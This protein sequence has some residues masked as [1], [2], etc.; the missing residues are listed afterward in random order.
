MSMPKETDIAAELSWPVPH[1]K[2][3]YQPL[4]LQLHKS[5]KDAESPVFRGPSYE[6]QLQQKRPNLSE[7][8]RIMTDTTG[9]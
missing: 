3:R 8:L 1:S 9:L 2:L 4:R 7:L 6:Q 5:N